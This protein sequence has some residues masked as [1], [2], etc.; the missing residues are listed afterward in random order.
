MAKF[1]KATNR[2][3]PKHT[4]PAVVWGNDKAIFEFVRGPSG[5]LECVTEDPAAIKLLRQ[6]GYDEEEQENM[7]IAPGPVKAPSSPNPPPNVPG[8]RK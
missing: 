3:Y 6:M 4:L 2:H 8:S 7:S 5:F 1:Y